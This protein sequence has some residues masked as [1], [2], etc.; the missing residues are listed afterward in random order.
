[1]ASLR[2]TR[3]R[4]VMILGPAEKQHRWSAWLH[5]GSSSR[6]IHMFGAALVFPALL[7]SFDFVSS[8]SCSRVP[9][10][11]Y[12]ATCT[13]GVVMGPALG[14]RLHGDGRV[15]RLLRRLVSVTVVLG[16]LGAAYMALATPATAGAGF[17]PSWSSKCAWRYC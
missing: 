10:S 13:I 4:K 11:W 8:F 1:F 7:A 15:S 6:R 17:P 9:L 3:E 2:G 16:M 14:A 5:V 12:L